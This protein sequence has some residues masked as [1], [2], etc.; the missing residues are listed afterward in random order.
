[1]TEK[2]YFAGAI[3]GTSMDGIDCA[4]VDLAGARPELIHTHF[5][6]MLE[7]LR[8]RL[9]T[10]C[11]PDTTNLVS[12]GSLDIEIGRQFATAINTLLDGAGVGP[13]QVRAIGSHGQTV[14]HQPE[15]DTPFTLQ[16]G[17]PNTI[18]CSTGITTVADFRR[19]DMAAGGQGAPLAPLFHQACFLH[20]TRNR[21]V[22]NVG[23]IANLTLLP[24]GDTGPV[25]GFD[26]GPANVLMDL[27]IQQHL[28]ENYDQA[29]R[30]ARS[31]NAHQEL[32]QQCLSEPYFSRPHPKSTGRELFNPDWLH[33]RLDAVGAMPPED[34]QATLLELSARSISD[35]LETAM[36]SCEE[37]ILCGGGAHNTALLARL[38]ELMG[39]ARILTSDT[40]G[41]P[42]DWVEAACFAWLA[43]QNLESRP[44]DC[45]RLTGACRPCVLGGRYQAGQLSR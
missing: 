12:L 10:L 1:M 30:W 11:H 6:P 44:V 4:L 26:T 14:Y 16:I 15:G 2:V 34:V 31:G 9:L 19:M 28:G 27:W 18:A 20:P 3:S 45:T 43:K 24:A 39:R 7:P 5:T 25:C 13:G 32:L 23:G 22:L 40:L 21:A 35:A 36:P 38:G 17:D 41:I 42:A 37:V 29:G 8:Q 33:R